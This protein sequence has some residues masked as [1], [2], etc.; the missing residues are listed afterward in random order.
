MR[1]CS[2]SSIQWIYKEYWP[3]LK[4]TE[5]LALPAAASPSHLVAEVK[6]EVTDSALAFLRKQVDYLIAANIKSWHMI[7]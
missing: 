2:H 3:D 5:H 6:L 1:L 7:S 4:N